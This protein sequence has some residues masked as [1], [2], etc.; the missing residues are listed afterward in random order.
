[1]IGLSFILNACSGVDLADEK[2]E[3]NQSFQEFKPEPKLPIPVAITKARLDNEA[4]FQLGIYEDHPEK[5]TI[6]QLYDQ[7]L[8]EVDS[9]TDKLWGRCCTEADMRFSEFL[10][11]KISCQT[12]NLKYPFSNVLD[13]LFATCFVFNERDDVSISIGFK[14]NNDMYGRLKNKTGFDVIGDTDTIQN[15]F[16]ISIVNGYAKSEQTYTE[17]GR[18]KEV[19]LWLNGV[20]KCNCRLMDTVAVQIVQGNFPFFKNDLIEMVPVSYYSGQKYDDVCISAIQRNLGYGTN[21]ELDK[22]S[23][24]WRY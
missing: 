7:S 21:P 15:Y 14:A 16:Q 3:V 9:W 23:K 11:F 17:N 18:I 6:Y 5:M 1:L 19:E 13:N 20:H 24:H 2:V 10:E 8:D 4:L 22:L 12:T